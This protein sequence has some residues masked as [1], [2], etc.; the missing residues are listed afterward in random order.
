ML[1]KAKKTTVSLVL[2]AGMAASLS[3]CGVTTF[4]EGSGS[5]VTSPDPN[6]IREYRKLEQEKIEQQNADQ[7]P[8]SGTTALDINKLA[9]DLKQDVQSVNFAP[10]S[11]VITDGGCG[12]VAAWNFGADSSVYANGSNCP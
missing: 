4:G 12:T 5:F 2:A 6:M 7:K 9:Q 8:S 11:T 10:G 1:K 3:A